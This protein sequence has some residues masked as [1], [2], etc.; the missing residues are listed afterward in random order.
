MVKLLVE[1]LCSFVG[2]PSSEV[3][4]TAFTVGTAAVLPFYT[5]MVVA[6]KAELVRFFKYCQSELLKDFFSSVL[7]IK[8]PLIL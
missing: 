6:P 8:L 2:V 5:V 7:K 1:F 4:S 3:A